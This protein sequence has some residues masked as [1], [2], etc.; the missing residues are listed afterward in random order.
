MGE[1]SPLVG[2]LFG[3]QH[4]IPKFKSGEALLNELGIRYEVN[5][6]SAHRTPKR[7]E[8]YCTEAAA[9]GIQVIIAGAGLSAALPGV[10]A[11]QCLLPVIG[12]PIGAGPLNGL[13]ALYAVV[14]MPPGV[15]VGSVGI[16]N[17]R[18]AVLLAARIIAL[19]NVDVK[20]K[21][22]DFVK[23]FGDL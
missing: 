9:R 6:Y 8:K 19:N 15:P 1:N 12:L 20:T 18:N 5:A 22:Q 21:L 10:V 17:A 2:V 13:D 4:D 16:D 14:Q 11:A 23:T 7:V 3:S